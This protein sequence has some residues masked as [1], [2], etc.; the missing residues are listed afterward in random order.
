M[1]EHTVKSG[2][3]FSSIAKSNG[4]F[5][6]LTLYNHA[7]N[8]KLKKDRPNPNMLVENDKVTVPDKKEKKVQVPVDKEHKF[9]VDRRKTK[10]KLVLQNGRNEGLVA[11]KCTIEVGAVKLIKA[12]GRFSP[13]LQLEI[14]AA[15]KDGKVE[16]VLPIAP[17]PPKKK[18]TSTSPKKHPPDIAPE[19]FTDAADVDRETKVLWTLKLGAL[20]PHTVVRGVMQRLHNL[21][22]KAPLVTAEN[23]DTARVVKAWQARQGVAKKDQTG[24]V[25]DIRAGVRTKHDEA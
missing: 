20:E 24:K 21:G 22:F 18:T 9:L 15:L 4:F 23:D 13:M 12:L 16:A 25:E 11:P 7:D 17:A 6:Y 1:A 10:L 5:N 8:A 3:C 14:D 19:A 2:D